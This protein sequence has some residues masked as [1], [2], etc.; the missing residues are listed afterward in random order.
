MK[1]RTILIIFSMIILS[2]CA[3][4]PNPMTTPAPTFIEIPTSTALP[5]AKEGSLPAV[6]ELSPV[7]AP[8]LPAVIPEFGE[9]DEST[10]LHISGTALEIK[11]E[12]YRLKVS[13][14]VKYPLNLTYD[15]LRCMPKVTM[16]PVLVCVGVFED[17]AQ[18]SGVP[19]SYILGLAGIQD[20]A[21]SV[22]LLSGDG[23]RVSY[24]VEE[25]LKEDIYL[26]YEWEGKPLPILHGFPVR[27]VAPTR[28]GSYWLKWLVEITVD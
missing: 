5:T 16:E 6:C 21:K 9:M 28:T 19:L 15:E 18:W 10:G 27:A 20:G 13:G 22:R 4:T 8:T 3:P 17:V 7:I 26:A 23:Y 24:A 2:A 12:D 1:K 14:K 11:L 25:A